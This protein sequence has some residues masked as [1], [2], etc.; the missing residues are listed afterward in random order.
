MENWKKIIILS[1]ILICK[2]I[3]TTKGQPPERSNV[4]F[5]TA[6]IPEDILVNSGSIW[7][8][9]FTIENVFQDPIPVQLREETNLMYNECQKNTASML[10]LAKLE[11]TV[12]NTTLNQITQVTNDTCMRILEIAKTFNE[13]KQLLIKD[14]DENIQTIKHLVYPRTDFRGNSVKR[15]RRAP[16]EFSV[17]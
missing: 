6:L 10:K 7:H 11:E 17:S 16:L 5:G 14:I 1:I 13:Q 3:S 8:H 15:Y 12:R 9:T 2:N 4:N